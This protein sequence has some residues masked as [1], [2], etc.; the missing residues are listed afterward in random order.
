[1]NSESSTSP[2]LIC[3]RNESN[4]LD[5][6]DAEICVASELGEKPQPHDYAERFPGLAEKISELVQMDAAAEVE[7]TP[8]AAVWP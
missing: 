1:M 4:L 5:L 2:A 8:A 7:M 6:I 3:I